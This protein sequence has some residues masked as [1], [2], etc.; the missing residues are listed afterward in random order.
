[1]D[2]QYEI[3]SRL[4]KV[5]SH[6]SRLEILNV[7]QEK[8]MTA[9]SLARLLNISEAYMHKHLGR[10]WDEG[11]IKKEGKEF[12]LTTS[13]RVFISLLEGMDVVGKFI[14]LWESHAVDK[15]PKELLGDM[16]VLKNTELIISAPRVLEK[17][18]DPSIVYEKR[19]MIAIDRIPKSVANTG[20]RDGLKELICGLEVERYTL[21]G[22][23][24]HFESHFKN[25]KI[26]SHLEIRSTSLENIYMGVAV[27]DEVEA[28]VIFP[29]DKGT[30]DWDYAIYGK[31][32]DFISWAEKNFWYMYE[33]GEVI[34]G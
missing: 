27:S 7:L 19:R 5:T 26:P 23:A 14:D 8:E 21:I 28:C 13:G 4:L 25:I 20:I 18:Y 16:R 1:M 12:A 33:R 24:P 3:T 2:S 9:K 30:L 29:D 6:K 34:G 15:I 32:P 17:F 10:L 22:P 31:D 11:L